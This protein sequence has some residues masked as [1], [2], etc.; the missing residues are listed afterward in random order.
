MY[1]YMRSHAVAVPCIGW[2]M[3]RGRDNI[4]R[5]AITKYKQF[6]QESMLSQV[7]LRAI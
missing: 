1:M 2:Y 4:P 7:C 5:E 6:K 3:V